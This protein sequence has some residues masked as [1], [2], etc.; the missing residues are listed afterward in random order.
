VVV[1][2]LAVV[3]C[4]W[5]GGGKGFFGG[6]GK[7]ERR[8]VLFWRA[9]AASAAATKRRDRFGQNSP[10]ARRRAAKV[11]VLQAQ[12]LEHDLA[13]L[14]HG[15]LAQGSGA[16]V[17]RSAAWLPSPHFSPPRLDRPA[18]RGLV[19]PRFQGWRRACA[20]CKRS[21]VLRNRGVCVR[22]E[23]ASCA[24][25]K[26][27]RARDDGG[28]RRFGGARRPRIASSLFSS[29]LPE[30][31]AAAEQRRREKEAAGEA[32]AAE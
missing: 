24:R 6:G 9:S 28:G 14:G 11:T 19:S 16:A 30:A 7:G 26:Q 18:C 31:A 10:H 29:T 12:L 23:G 5:G 1:E 22:R 20:C 8:A 27:R 15:C 2:E 25:R 32:R 17:A 21:V 13:V 3:V 4:V